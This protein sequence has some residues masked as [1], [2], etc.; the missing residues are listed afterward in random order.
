MKAFAGIIGWG[1]AIIVATLSVAV[2]NYETTWRDV[3]ILKL[4]GEVKTQRQKTA[5]ADLNH[6]EKMEK[7][8]GLVEKLGPLRELENEA[9][10]IQIRVE[11]LRARRA[12][13]TDS[14]ARER[15]ILKEAEEVGRLGEIAAAVKRLR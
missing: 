1:V 5:A 12:A 13:M 2:V 6:L 4:R 8:S 14:G 11:Q 10:E 9:Y 15:S 3:E 7:V